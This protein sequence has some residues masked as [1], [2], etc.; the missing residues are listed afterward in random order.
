[1]IYVERFLGDS[2]ESAKEENGIRMHSATNND[3]IFLLMSQLNS[4]YKVCQISFIANYVIFLII[5]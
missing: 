5:G 2:F 1:M 3:N 4:T